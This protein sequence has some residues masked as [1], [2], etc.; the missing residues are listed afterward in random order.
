M[1]FKN[2]ML[3]KIF[4][5]KGSKK[6]RIGQASRKEAS[7]FFFFAYFAT[8]S[9]VKNNKIYSDRKVSKMCC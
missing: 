9:Y 3:K 4:G 1:F 7:Q 8:G 6:Q 2:K 5:L